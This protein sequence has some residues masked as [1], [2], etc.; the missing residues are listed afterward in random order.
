M[1]VTNQINGVYNTNNPRM[2]KYMTTFNEMMVSFDTMK[3]EQVK[4]SGNKRVDA[5]SK[6]VA[7]TY[8]H[9]SKNMLVELLKT[10]A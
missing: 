5:L 8:S 7:T 1:L 2:K 9:L 4:R 6:L 10:S 3:I